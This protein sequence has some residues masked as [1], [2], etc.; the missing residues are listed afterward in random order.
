MVWAQEY[1]AGKRRTKR[2]CNSKGLVSLEFGNCTAAKIQFWYRLFQNWILKVSFR[3][4]TFVCG[5]NSLLTKIHICNQFLLWYQNCIFIDSFVK[6]VFHR[7]NAVNEKFIFE[8]G[9]FSLNFKTVFY[10]IHLICFFLVPS[11][12]KVG[13]L[14]SATNCDQLSTNQNSLRSI[15]PIIINH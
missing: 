4:C 10:K 1:R 7:K 2:K 3:M 12:Y 9:L 6:F 11:V 15:H 13:L 8:C 5:F 14:H